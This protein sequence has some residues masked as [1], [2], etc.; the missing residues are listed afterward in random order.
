MC[1]IRKSLEL[2]LLLP[3]AVM[4]ERWSDE[5]GRVWFYAVQKDGGAE[6]TGCAPVS[7][8]LAIPAIV[9]GH[10]V[11][12]VGQ[13]AFFRS[14]ELVSVQIPEGVRTIGYDAFYWCPCLQSVSLPSGLL[15]IDD[16]A[17]GACSAL[18]TVELPDTVN[19]IGSWVFWSTGLRSIVIPASVTNM[20]ACVFQGCSSLRSMT[21]QSAVVKMGHQVLCLCSSLSDVSLPEGMT[22]IPEGLFMSCTSLRKVDIPMSVT[23][24]AYTAFYGCTGLS[25]LY[26]PEGL[27]EIGGKAFFGCTRLTTVNIPAGVT[28]IGEEAFAQ[29]PMLAD[30]AFNAVYVHDGWVIGYNGV[31]PEDLVL[32]ENV[33]GFAAG[34]MSGCADLESVVIPASLKY[35]G[36]EVFRDCR[37]LRDVWFAG[38]APELCGEKIYS[39]TS[40]NLVT[41]VAWGSLGWCRVGETGIPERWQNRSIDYGLIPGSEAYHV[42]FDAAGGEAN[43]E[44]VEVPPNTALGELAVASRA[45]YG[46][47][48]W[49][50]SLDDENE[51]RIDELVDS[52]RTYYARWTTNEYTVSF[53]AGIGEGYMEEQ[54]FVYDRE[55][56]L[57]SNTFERIGYSFA[58]WSTGNVECVVYADGEVVSNLTAVAEDVFALQAVWVPNLYAVILDANGGTVDPETVS[59]T[60]DMP[61]GRL[62]VPSRKGYAFEGWFTDAEEDSPVSEQFVVLGDVTCHARWTPVTYQIHYGQTRSDGNT[63]PKTYT[64]EDEI[65]FAPLPDVPGYRFAGWSPS[66]VKRGT[67]GNLEV[68]AKWNLVR[69]DITYVG[70]LDVKNP[71]P[72]SYTIEDAVAFAPLPN[73]RGWKFVGW[74]RPRIDR[75]STGPVTVVAGWERD[76]PALGGDGPDMEPMDADIANTYDGMIAD[77][78]GLP[79]GTVNVKAGAKSKLDGT[80]KVTVTIQMAGEAKKVSIKGRVVAKEAEFV[81][82]AADGRVLDLLF[83]RNTISGEFDGYAID[84]A[85]N[86]LASKARTPLAKAERAAAENLLSRFKDNYVLAF[87]DEAGWNGLSMQIMAKGKVRISG[88]L[89]DGTRIATSSQ[90]I[91]GEDYCCI[92]VFYAKKSNKVSL[93]VYFEN[94][95]GEVSAFGPYDAVISKVSQLAA[96][97]RFYVEDGIY[98]LF[99]ETEFADEFLPNDLAIDVQGGKWLVANGARAGSVTFVDGGFIDQTD[100][101]NPSGLKLTYTAKTGAFKG[102]FNV[103]ALVNGRVKKFMATVNGIVV[104]GNGYGTAVIKKI[105]CVPIMIE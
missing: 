45:G 17:F 19:E 51:A 65:E 85:R 64:I 63:N 32:D 7:S 14:P 97:S 89:V 71:N 54:R 53:D 87:E 23:N 25:S 91:V 52:D 88:S 44:S 56:P 72:A 70:V 47:V 41:H 80:C 6:I 22:E 8:N 28:S 78:D 60:Y 16:S 75:G 30:G 43:V 26:L 57:A 18:R 76:V 15:R 59:G 38:Q 34:A 27:T 37:S 58:G 49:F 86:L 102:S 103:Y 11:V 1:L 77:E 101:L 48:G 4:A 2:L 81:A 99:D 83:T 100:S 79:I 10:N 98:D 67:D 104:D 29:T 35:L 93:C 21:N 3:L 55:Q 69:Y 105:G 42:E 84:G 50:R 96:D 5:E 20:G 39:G 62:P 92:P 73:V 9:D 95:Q 33:K 68:T 94:A 61:L 82:K 12:S 31:G 90:M 36:T 40:P 13:K 46:F 74:S 24:I 66:S